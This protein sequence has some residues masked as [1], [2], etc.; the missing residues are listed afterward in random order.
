MGE[1]ASTGWET[2]HGTEDVGGG[3]RSLPPAVALGFG[4]S[5]ARVCCGAD[6]RIINSVCAACVTAGQTASG[7]SECCTGLH[8]DSSQM[9]CKVG[10]TVTLGTPCA[11]PSAVGQCAVGRVTS[12]NATT[13]APVCTAVAGATT[14]ICDGVDNDCN[15]TVDDAEGVG[16][17]CSSATTYEDVHGHAVTACANSASVIGG[18]KQCN[19]GSAMP[20]CVA[21]QDY[22]YCTICGAGGSGP[23]DQYGRTT[24]DCGNCAGASCA[25]PNH[26]SC[27][28]NS[29]CGGVPATCVARL[30]QSP[31]YHWAC[32]T[33]ASIGTETC[34][35]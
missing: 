27:N 15:G 24:M 35:P 32:W 22:D 1:L 2:D 9:K 34:P 19:R 3:E 8:F 31:C 10:C 6:R 17:S 7:A 4:A 20:Q 33:A 29:V 14:E 5:D 16:D 18:H 13:G 23:L 30:N 21:I 25:I 28:P 12:C 11:V 26:L